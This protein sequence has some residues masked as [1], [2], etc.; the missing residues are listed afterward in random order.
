M[1]LKAKIKVD[2]YDL[3][4]VKSGI[5]RILEGNKL[6]AMST[7]SNGKS[8]INTAYFCFDEFL[9]VFV[10]N[11]LS[12]QHVA[13][14]A[15]NPSAALA[16]YDSTQPIDSKRQGLQIFGKC[17]KAEGSLAEKGLE[18]YLARF[19]SF[20]QWL[21]NAGKSLEYAKE[22]V[23]VTEPD[24]LK[25]YDEPDFGHVFIKAEIEK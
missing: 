3:E 12:S 20:R 5:M 4:K 2:G 13:N 1:E 22:M 10:L 7:I 15:E 18:L 14:L 9:N 19:P 25:L 17:T 24:W 23:Y 16:V 21:Q 6:L 8:Y 11:D